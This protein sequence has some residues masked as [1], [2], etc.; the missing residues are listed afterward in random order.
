MRGTIADGQQF[1][2]Q[3]VSAML[4][5]QFFVLDSIDF[6]FKILATK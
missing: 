1:D 2:G 6:V 5:L 4:D 3:L